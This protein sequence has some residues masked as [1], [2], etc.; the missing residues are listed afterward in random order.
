MRVASKRTFP[1]GPGKGTKNTSN[2]VQKK[3]RREKDAFR[4][5]SA[6]LFGAARRNAGDPGEDFRRGTRTSKDRQNLARGS[7][8][9]KQGLGKSW[10]GLGTAFGTPSLASQGRRKRLRAFRRACL[11]ERR[12]VQC[13]QKRFLYFLDMLVGVRRF[14]RKLCKF[15]R[16]TWIFNNFRCFMKYVS[17]FTIPFSIFAGLDAKMAPFGVP[18]VPFWRHFEGL[19]HP[20]GPQR[21]P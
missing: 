13:S 2:R 6:R 3:T 17:S 7:R 21:D 14:P 9:G 20:W 4:N 10:A 16:I 8:S 15:V 12:F 5:I 18:R 11:W 19:G 1:T